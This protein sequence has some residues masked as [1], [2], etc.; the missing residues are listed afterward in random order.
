[1]SR[2]ATGYHCR[3]K[4]YFDETS[5]GIKNFV[6]K[7][8]LFINCS[9]SERKTFPD[10]YFQ[11]I[12]TSVT[13][14]ITVWGNCNNQ[15]TLTPSKNYTVAGRISFNLPRDTLSEAVLDL[16]RWHSIYDLY[17]LS[18]LKLFYNIV[19]DNIPPFIPDWLYDVTVRITWED[20]TNP[21]FCDF[22]PIL[23]KIIF[24]ITALYN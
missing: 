10:L 24:V 6:T 9:F 13:D 22:P 18:L 8:N 7:L 5:Y 11:V 14:D 19:S 17:K 23:W 1:M 20:I 21:L 2:K 16:T 3:L 4:T 12:L 15:I